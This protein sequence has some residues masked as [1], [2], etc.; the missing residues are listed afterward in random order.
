MAYPPVIP[1][2]TRSNATDM[3]DV[4]AADHNALADA[5]TNM[6]WGRVASVVNKGVSQSIPAANTDLTG[7]AL[8]FTRLAGRVYVAQFTVVYQQNVA[9]ATS[10]VFLASGDGA[11][12]YTN[13]GLTIVNGGYVTVTTFCLLP[14]G[15]GPLPLKLRASPGGGTT[16]TILHG[17][18]NASVL[19]VTD[20][21]PV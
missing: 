6:G 1:P 14:S 9:N 2:N 16:L 20:V 21:G 11:T 13:P 12:I 7:M 19:I 18:L 17:S 15:T 8:T 3:V 4:H 5:L 10:N